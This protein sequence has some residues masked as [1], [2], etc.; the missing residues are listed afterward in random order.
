MN[1][2]SNKGVTWSVSGSGCSSNACGTLSAVTS[3]TV[4]YTAPTTAAV[5]LVT[6]TSVADP[7]K[8]A[9]ATIGVTDLAGVFT[10]RNDGTRTSINNKE[11]LLTPSNVNTSSFGKIF[12][13]PVEGSVYAQPLWVSN[14]AIG[15][16]THNIVIVATQ[17]DSVYAFDADNG[18]GTTCTQ[19]WKASMLTSTH[20]AAA[21]ATPVP[22]ADTGETGD[23]PTEIG[24]TS[25]PVIDPATKYLFVVSKTKEGGA[26]LSSAC[27]G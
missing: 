9:S 23:I 14:V 18:S 2:S 8:T 3:T 12:T 25:T 6:A 4:K 24:I 13:C 10:Y 22:P 16:G 27:T 11:Y 26:V 15:G 7:T 19:Y 20:G 5:Y 17:H 1:D 21:G